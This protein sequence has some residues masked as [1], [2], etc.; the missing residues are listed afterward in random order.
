MTR[1]T[2]VACRTRQDSSVCV[3]ARSGRTATQPDPNEVKEGPEERPWPGPPAHGAAPV[4]VCRTRHAA[5]ES[6]CNRLVGLVGQP[7]CRIRATSFGEPG[8]AS[9]E[10]DDQEDHLGRAGGAAIGAGGHRV[11]MHAGDV[12]APRRNPVGSG[13]DFGN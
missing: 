13:Q 1:I 9:D 5:R 7:E 12:D 4:I 11:R 6:D 2:G 3:A 8:R 10:L